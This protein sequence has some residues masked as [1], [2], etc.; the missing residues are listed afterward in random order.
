MSLSLE[1]KT[2]L[3]TGASR[4]I[5]RAIAERLAADGA[6]VIIN[7][8][9]NQQPAQERV[10]AIVAKGGKAVA[11]QADVSK[12]AEVRRL[13]NEAEKA[14]EGLDKVIAN[15]GIHIV[16]P[17]IE[18]TEADY[19]YIFDIN[20]RGVFFTLQEAARRVRNGGR[21]VVVS[22]GG[23]IMHFANMSLYLGS[24]GAIEQFARSVA[25]AR[26]GQC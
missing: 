17:L 20:T 9:R 19:D 8:A 3:I 23:T 1:G 5:G 26:P 11:I 7:Y 4:G 25:R 24:K 12:P 13:F 16:K 10:S 2:A 22:T 14:M 15:A 6:A 21:I 18:N